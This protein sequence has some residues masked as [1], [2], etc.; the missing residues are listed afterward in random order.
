MSA[1]GDC[2]EPRNGGTQERC[3]TCHECQNNGG[4]PALLDVQ[5]RLRGN[6]SDPAVGFRR[7][8]PGG[9]RYQPNQFAAVIGPHTLMT[10]DRQQN[11]CSFGPRA[12]EVCLLAPLAAAK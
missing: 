10:G 4:S 7:G 12:G 2:G 11:T 5:L 3:S 6:F 9:G 8:Q 1:S